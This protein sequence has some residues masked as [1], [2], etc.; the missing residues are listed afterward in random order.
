MAKNLLQ[1]NG[2]VRHF[3]AQTVL[4]TDKNSFLTKVNDE[5]MMKPDVILEKFFELVDYCKGEK[6]SKFRRS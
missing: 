6:H 5:C 2:S 4:L 3:V 1:S